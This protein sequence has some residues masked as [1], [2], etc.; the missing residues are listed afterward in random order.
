MSLGSNA[1]GRP[2][3]P[4]IAREEFA[5]LRA[6]IEESCGILLPDDKAYLVESRLTELL[7][8]QNCRSFYEL[9]RK[10]RDDTSTV[11]RDKIIDAITTRETYWFRDT[12][13]FDILR[14][15]VLSEVAAQF[16]SGRRTSVRIWCAGC[17]T[18]QEPYSVAMTLV[19]YCRRHAGMTPGQFEVLATDIASSALYVARS[20]RYSGVEVERGLSAEYR[21]RYFV[22][23]GSVWVLRDEVRN[24]VVFERHNLQDP[25]AHPGPF[26]MVFCRNVL[27]YFGE[28]RK[29]RIIS[30]IGDTLRDTGV[31]VVGSAE[32]LSRHSDR[33]K[34]EKFGTGMYYRPRGKGG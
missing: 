29:R 18:G 10:A 6:Y 22:R 23:T 31:L 8:E 20:A 13:P 17:S 26:D 12:T 25:F 5:L 24:M 4:G 21:D 7:A 27:I 34:M 30:R 32:A 16:R 9:Y 28:S 2:A 33:L 3:A 14:D 11:L 1:S 15:V 19:E